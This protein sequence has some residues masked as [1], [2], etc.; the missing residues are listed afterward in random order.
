MISEISEEKKA[1]CLIQLE[2]ALDYL[3]H[4]FNEKLAKADSCVP[5]SFS[6]LNSLL[7]T[8]ALLDSICRDR[9]Y[10]LISDYRN[11][12]DNLHKCL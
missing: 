3:K 7:L 1:E 9:P 8:K 11:D 10:E 6:E 2:V 12:A 4:K 5:N